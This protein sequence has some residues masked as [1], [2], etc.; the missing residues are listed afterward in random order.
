MHIVSLR[1]QLVG[2]FAKLFEAFWTEKICFYSKVSRRFGAIH[3]PDRLCPYH[4]RSSYSFL[5][6]TKTTSDSWHWVSW[7]SRHQYILGHSLFL[8]QKIS[9]VMGLLTQSREG[10]CIRTPFSGGVHPAPNVIVLPLSSTQWMM[11]K[12]IFISCTQV[13][14]TRQGQCS[15][16]LWSLGKRLPWVSMLI[17]SKILNYE[18]EHFFNY[19]LL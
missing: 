6:R 15:S 16:W 13:I 19:I 1:C 10:T 7:I 14:F 17:P 3:I 18:H 8:G 12:N 5:Q 4:W 2:Y 9:V 11:M